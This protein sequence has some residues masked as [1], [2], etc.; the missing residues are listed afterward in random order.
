MTMC[1]SGSVVFG[2]QYS[3]GR[4]NKG[5][6]L[7]IQYSASKVLIFLRVALGQVHAPYQRSNH[8]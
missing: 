1:V 2:F 4:S 8:R 5:I 7:L 6:V 3:D